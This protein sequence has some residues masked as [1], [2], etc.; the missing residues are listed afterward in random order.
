MRSAIISPTVRAFDPAGTTAV[1]GTLIDPVPWNSLTTDLGNEITNSLPRNG[2]A[3]MTA[4]LQASAG[5]ASL[6]S[7]TF[8][9]AATTGFYLKSATE[10][11]IVSSAVEI[12]S[13][14]SYG[15]HF[16]AVGE[17][18][19]VNLTGTVGGVFLQGHLYGLTLSNNASDATNDID[20]GVG[21]AA[22]DGATPYMQHHI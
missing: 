7:L 5:T 21:A 19:N 16:D 14:G 9:T 17:L 13:F 22:S 12:A 15:L 10:I 4:P 2:S 1:S 6:P 18:Q 20:I 11:G 3:P 8:N